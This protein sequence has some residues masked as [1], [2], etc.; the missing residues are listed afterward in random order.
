[1]KNL[2]KKIALT[3]TLLLSFNTIPTFANTN[4]TKENQISKIENKEALE[5]FKNLNKN[6]KNNRNL[7]NINKN[8]MLNNEFEELNLLK[9]ENKNDIEVIYN[10]ENEN[11][12]TVIAYN[13]NSNSNILLE[14]N[15]KTG[16]IIIAINNEEYRLTQEGENINAYSENGNKIPILITEYQSDINNIRLPMEITNEAR[17]TFGKNYGPFYKTNKVLVDVLGAVGTI[18]GVA[19]LKIK[20]PLLGIVSTIAGAISWV[21]NLAYAT[22]YIKFYQAYAVND[23]TYV[24]ETQYYYNY[25]NYTSLVKTRTWYF[26][27][28]KPY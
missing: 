6:N 12:A 11:I 18:G 2:F 10:A 28:S 22:L 24:K 4:N 3:L 15:N 17:T 8:P 20:H 14:A 7:K 21:G 27:S 13:Q 26:Y 16:D 9:I 19:A 5:L 25:N 1:M 23:P